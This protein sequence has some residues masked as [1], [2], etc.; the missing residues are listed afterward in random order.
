MSD[1]S[2]AAGSPLERMRRRYAERRSDVHLDLP[3]PGATWGGELVARVRIVDE[4][5]ARAAIV[6]SAGDGLAETADIV[7]AA[8]EQLMTRAPDGSLEPLLDEDGAVL[9]FDERLGAALGS[10]EYADGRS[11]VLLVFSEGDPAVVN[12]LAL[13]G[14]VDRLSRWASDT[15]AEIEGAIATGR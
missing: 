2:A 8:V 10:P 1:A 15:A 12:V 3:I 5:T 4:R 7:A 14:F 6:A 13:G 11:A 9:R